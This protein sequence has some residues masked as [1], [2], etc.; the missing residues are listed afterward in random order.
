MVGV[1]EDAEEAELQ[2]EGDEECDLNAPRKSRRRKRP[3][4]AKKRNARRRLVNAAIRT[5][6][7]TFGPEEICR[8]KKSIW[9]AS[10]SRDL[11][12]L[13][14]SEQTVLATPWECSDKQMRERSSE[15]SDH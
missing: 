15:W 3:D 12:R 11:P 14:D 8:V 7:M 10:E 1:W 13:M 9:S 6:Q 2:E 4:D 5:G